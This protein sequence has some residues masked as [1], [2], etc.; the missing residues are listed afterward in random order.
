MWI[1]VS[2]HEEDKIETK[3]K[4]VRVNRRLR[5][6]LTNTSKAYFDSAQHDFEIIV[7]NK[8]Q[9]NERDLR[10]NTE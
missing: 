4:S 10:E 9:N 5:F 2:E 6:D 1:P 7:K 3:S 8:G